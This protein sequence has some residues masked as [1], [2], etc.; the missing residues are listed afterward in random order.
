MQRSGFLKRKSLKHIIFLIVFFNI[1]YAFAINSEDI[2]KQ[3]ASAFIKEYN[4]SISNF[5]IDSQVY[6]IFSGHKLSAY[7]FNINPNGFVVINNKSNQVI[8]Y[9]FENDLPEIDSP[10]WI[11]FSDFI[12]S[13]EPQP[14]ATNTIINSR[15]TI[16]SVGPFVYSLW[17]QV[18]CKDNYGSTVNV[19]NIYTPNNYAV[20]CVAVSMS[21]LMKHYNWPANGTGSHTYTDNYGSSQGTYSADFVN[22][23]YPWNNML[24][25]YNNKASSQ[26]QREAAGLL[27]FHAAVALEMDFE[28]N[29]ST[30]NVSSIPN[31][32]KNYFR[33]SSTARAYSSSNFWKLLDS[34]MVY[35]IPVVLAIA[36][37]GYGH[38]IVCDGMKIEADSSY[39]YHLNM[40]WWGS[41]NGWYRLKD[42]WNA[43]GYSEITGAVFNF[44]PIPKLNTPFYSTE[45]DTVMI[46]WEYPETINF[47][48]FELQQLFGANS[49]ETISDSLTGKSISLVLDSEI[50]NKFRLRAKNNGI[51][52][53]DGWS[54]TKTAIWDNTGIVD[55]YNRIEFTISPNPTSDFIAFKTRSKIKNFKIQIFDLSGKEV[56][57]NSTYNGLNNKIVNIRHLKPNLYILNITSPESTS[58]I[59]LIKL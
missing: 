31:A 48:A 32:G 56:Y 6:E 46:S 12:S 27:N 52:A 33:Y 34:N 30:S 45:T 19:T 41:T 28:Y 38:S 44:L 22:T 43:G 16:Y 50:E 14:K 11:V 51:W 17:G 26:T 7:V 25:R 29:G 23:D 35:Q 1:T 18:N 10:E 9:S 47:N 42:D 20:G 13:I 2:A 57:S 39:W 3:K 21:T 59:K 24:D 55:N 8:S 37:N 36:G 40:G 4:P 53:F 58:S 54:E 15:E 49:W 5:E